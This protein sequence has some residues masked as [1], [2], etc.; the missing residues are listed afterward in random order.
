MDHAGADFTSRSARAEIAGGRKTARAVISRR[1]VI[2]QAFGGALVVLL[3]RPELAVAHERATDPGSLVLL[4]KGLYRPVG[5]PPDLGLSTVDL[6]D[7]SYTKTK[8]Y[9]VIG[10]PGHADV[11]KAIGLFYAQSGAPGTLC[12]YDLPDGAIAMRFTHQAN[13]K[14]IPDG[15]GGAYFYGTQGL[16]IIEANGSYSSLVG[17]HNRMVDNLHHLASGDWDEYCFCFIT[18][19]AN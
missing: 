7:G 10:T 3:A 16:K 19:P 13:V 18:G 12:A 6:N 17:G 9:P 11:L 8:I 4:L 14:R 15:A 2:G 5:N 1:A